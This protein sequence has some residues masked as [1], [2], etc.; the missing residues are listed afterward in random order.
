MED[1]TTTHTSAST[2]PP[3][4][5]AKSLFFLDIEYLQCIGKMLLMLRHALYC[6][7]GSLLAVLFVFI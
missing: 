1:K 6:D 5:V 3:S 7:H 4:G 2:L